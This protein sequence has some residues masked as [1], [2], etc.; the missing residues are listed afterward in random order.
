MATHSPQASVIMIVNPISN[1]LEVET[2]LTPNGATPP[3]LRAT[4]LQLYTLQPPFSTGPSRPL[5]SQS[6]QHSKLIGW[7][8]TNYDRFGSAEVP[9]EAYDQVGADDCEPVCCH[10]VVATFISTCDVSGEK[11]GEAE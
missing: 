10:G 9:V 3:T 4:L 7:E 2:L 5:S 8:D 1:C 11:G 6:I